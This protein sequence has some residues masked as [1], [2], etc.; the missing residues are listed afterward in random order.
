VGAAALAVGLL[1]VAPGQAAVGQI[2]TSDNYRLGNDA[3]PL[4]GKDAPGLAVDPA[5]PNHIVEVQLDLLNFE[6]QFNTSTDGGTTWRGGNLEAPPGFAQDGPCSVLGHGANAMDAGVAFG[7]GQNVYVAWASA[8]GDDGTTALVSKSTDG[9]ASFGVATVA[10]PGGAGGDAP[11]NEYPKLAVRPGAGVGGADKIIV[12]TDA[13]E[14]SE[15]DH[16]LTGRVRTTVSNDGGATWSPVV[17]ANAPVSPAN[18]YGAIEHT[19]P[20]FGPNGEIYIAWR[21]APT[22]AP[23][24]PTFQDGFIQVGKSTDGGATWSQVNATNV[25]GEIVGTTRFCCSSFPRLAVNPASGTLYL[26]WAQNAGLYPPATFAAQ[27]HFMNQRSQV[28]FMRST[29]ASATWANRRQISESPWGIPPT[30]TQTRHPNVSVAPDG[31][32]D[33]VWQDRR[34]AYRPCLQTHAACAET[35]LGDTYYAY[36]ADN[37]VSFAPNRRITDRSM[38][39]DVGFDY[40]FSTYWNF[41]PVAA[42]LGTDRLLFAWQ[43][44]REGNFDNDTQDIYLA[45]T[46]L[47]AGPGATPIKNVGAQAPI[48]LS[49]TLSRLAQPGGSEALLASTFATRPATKVVIAKNG[50]VAGVLAGGVL[51]RANVG[52]LLLSPTG[53]LTGAVKA[54]VARMTPVGAYIVGDTATLSNQV[55]TD[56]A[57][58]GVPSDQI[59]RIAASAAADK[60][61]QI[62][63]ALDRRSATDKTAGLPAFD[64]VVIANDTSPDASAASTLAVNRRLPV[65]YVGRNAIPT[66]TTDALAALN[67]TKTLVVGGPGAVSDAVVA[68]LASAGRNPTR[69]GGA[70]QYATSVAVLQESIARGLP[71]NQVFVAD[72]TNPLHGALLGAASGRIGGLLLLTHGGS[73]GEAELTARN[74]GLAPKLDRLISSYLT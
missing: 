29:D 70:D 62:A 57:D 28:W 60:A 61:K 20:V 43:D 69:L 33:V 2:R 18:P 54:E 39:N 42:A 32:V 21:T 9:G 11:D 37:G 74:L 8:Q 68:Q 52:P 4:R 48:D 72:G 35:R 26:V 7:S 22:V 46:N 64:A 31:R 65:L 17:I 55:A 73:V 40:R 56:L 5:N 47:N 49:V 1:S 30:E 34:H 3:N 51:A 38:N 27:D 53:G 45:K 63:L 36:S 67:I 12:A 16:A 15:G 71:T 59:T 25:K 23:N 10:I 19:Q 50:D 24:D 44:S 66:A 6:C 41:G 14:A 58:A 13:T